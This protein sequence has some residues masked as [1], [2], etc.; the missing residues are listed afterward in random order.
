MTVVLSGLGV[1]ESLAKE[2]SDL[3]ISACVGTVVTFQ[4]DGELC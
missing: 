2:I 3:L 1:P 4:G